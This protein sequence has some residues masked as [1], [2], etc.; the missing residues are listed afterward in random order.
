MS[1]DDPRHGTANGYNN[2]GCR[3]DRCRAAWAAYVNDRNHRTGRHVPR[4]V[5]LA[6]MADRPIPHGTESGYRD[7][8]CRCR[9][10]RDAS[11]YA[12]RRRSWA[13]P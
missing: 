7:R 3:C 1:P 2:L 11:A 12:R 13:S 9:W 6:E 4:D 8:G 5:Y 10:C